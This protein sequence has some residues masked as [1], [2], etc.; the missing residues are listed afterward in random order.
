M[1]T[2]ALIYSLALRVRTLFQRLLARAIGNFNNSGFE[3]HSV[4][5]KSK[6]LFFFRL[7]LTAFYHNGVK[8]RKHEE[9][10]SLR[11]RETDGGGDRRCGSSH[12]SVFYV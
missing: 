1:L 8:R 5:S 3:F 7:W 10:K 2:A 4:S 12:S 11:C 9:S 6:L